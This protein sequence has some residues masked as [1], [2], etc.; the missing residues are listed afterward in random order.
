[1]A[2]FRGSFF[3]EGLIIGGNFTFQNGLGLTIKAANSNSPCAYI[4]EALL[5]KGYLHLGFGRLIFGRAY[6]WEGLLS[7][8]YGISILLKN[9]VISFIHF[10]E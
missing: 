10:E 2:Y 6:F 3:S 7:E 8:F 9:T 4:R 1:M 5:S